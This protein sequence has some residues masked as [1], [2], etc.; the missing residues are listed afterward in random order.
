MLQLSWKIFP[1]RKVA[2]EVSSL[3]KKITSIHSVKKKDFHKVKPSIVRLYKWSATWVWKIGEFLSGGGSTLEGHWPSSIVC[4]E[5]YNG[6]VGVS[7]DQPNGN[8]DTKLGNSN[9]Q[10][11]EFASNAANL[12]HEWFGIVGV[13]KDTWFSRLQTGRWNSIES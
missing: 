10:Q 7:P 9:Q 2:I 8:K 4:A 6:P 13:E 5:N 3:W 12:F 11:N 1:P